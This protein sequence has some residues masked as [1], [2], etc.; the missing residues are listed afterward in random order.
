VPSPVVGQ[1]VKITIDYT[2]AVK[3]TGKVSAY[4]GP[5]FKTLPLGIPEGSSELP[6]EIIGDFEYEANVT[7]GEAGD[8]IIYVVDACEDCTPCTYNITVLPA[9]VCP[10]VKFLDYTWWEEV[11]GKGFTFGEYDIPGYGL[12]NVD[13]TVTFANKIEKE[14]V[15]VYV[16][17]PGLGPIFMP[18]PMPPTALQV[19]MTTTD[20]VTYDGT[21]PIGDIKEV[22]V[23]V[24]NHF[25]ED[26]GAPTEFWVDP[27]QP[28]ESLPSEILYLIHTLGC[29]PLRI[30]VLAGDPCCIEVCEYPFIVDP[31][32]P[33]ANLK[34]EIA[35]CCLD[36]ET[37]G[38]DS[39]GYPGHEII[40]S[41]ETPGPCLVEECCGDTCSGVAE[42][43]LHLCPC[44]NKLPFENTSMPQ[45]P[46]DECCDFTGCME[47][48]CFYWMYAEGTECPEVLVSDCIHDWAD[49][50][51]LHPAIEDMAISDVWTSTW[52]LYMKM[53][54]NA[55]NTTE[56]KAKMAF[57]WE[58]SEETRCG[59]ETGDFWTINILGIIPLCDD[60]AFG[61]E[62]FGADF[63]VGPHFNF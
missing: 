17:I 8:R 15:K 4:V 29:I 14:L 12:T 37:P 54:D 10:V 6:L 57:T 1:P 47:P 25:L 39:P 41:V 5:A 18:I 62:E 32:G 55:G 43:E 28:F 35:E 34:V 3:P 51:G 58:P 53:T 26:M 59:N 21:I 7:F 40:V 46:F 63:C 2:D 49:P 50:Y 19:A 30:Y 52:Y 48:D 44:Y 24:I 23:G 60:A 45:G 61:D 22:V 56:Y 11:D 13:F 33:F 9:D 31:V 16:G 20:E 27:D 38:C 42:W 36:C